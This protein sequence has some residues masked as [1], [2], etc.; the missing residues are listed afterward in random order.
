MSHFIGLCFGDFW[1][2]N[3]EYYSET[4]EVEYYIAYTKEE[5]IEEVKKN[6]LIEYNYALKKISDTN[7]DQE[8]K[9]RFDKI[10][11]AGPSI[12]DEEAWKEASEWGY[13]IDEIENLLTTYNPNSKWDWYSI[14]GRWDGFICLKEKDSE[15]NP[16]RVNQARFS[17]IDW[18]YMFNNNK[19]P[20]C[21]VEVDG[22]WCEKG[23]M[24]WFGLVSNESDESS[25]NS[26][27][28]DY[29]RFLDDDCL[30]TAVDFHI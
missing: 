22:E 21:Y 28:K 3:L 11:K 9:N 20:F 27:F 24:G 8:T 26:Q 1:E 29:V 7:L 25:W 17:E 18:D 6:R 13:E 23:E 2:D 30:V 4:R 19:I 5:A 10:V 12:S 16:M 15:G 14:G